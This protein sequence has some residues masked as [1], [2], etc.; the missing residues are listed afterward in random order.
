MERELTF[1][2]PE[3]QA[4]LEQ[5]ARTLCPLT[6]VVEVN[7]LS[8]PRGDDEQLNRWSDMGE[9]MERFDG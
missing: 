1:V 4:R 6:E 2:S 7:P 5:L 3:Y 8:I 9:Y